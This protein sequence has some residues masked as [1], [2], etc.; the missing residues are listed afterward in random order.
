VSIASL[1]FLG[2]EALED[3]PQI[4]LILGKK[5]KSKPQINTGYVYCIYK[6]S[7]FFH[8]LIFRFEKWIERHQITFIVLTPS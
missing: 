8:D 5:I 7:Y 3:E 6:T 2:L 1:D 4:D